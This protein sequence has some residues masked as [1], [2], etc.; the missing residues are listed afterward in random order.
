MFPSYREGL[1]KALIEAAAASRAVITTDVPGCRDVI[2]PD[3]SGI[4]VPVKDSK[5]L[6]DA[7]EYLIDNPEVR[8]SMGKEGRK[9]AEDN[10]KIE[11][12]II[13]HLEIY[14]NLQKKI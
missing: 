6:A 11:N 5:K 14:K 3:K 8:V 1:P 10:F 4:L 9:F 13:N 7:I 12:I 2:I